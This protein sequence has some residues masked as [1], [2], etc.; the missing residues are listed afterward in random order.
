MRHF[1]KLKLAEPSRVSRDLRGEHVY[2]SQYTQECFGLN[3]E[4]PRD[5]NVNKGSKYVERP[6]H[7]PSSNISKMNECIVAVHVGLM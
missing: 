4:R 3:P 5:S 2:L 7:L 1:F 6:S